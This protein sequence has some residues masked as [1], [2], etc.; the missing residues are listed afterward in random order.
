MAGNDINLAALWVPVMPETK[1]LGPEM[2]KAGESAK[3]EFV[4]GFSGGM[5]PDA[6]GKQWATQFSRSMTATMGQI[7]MPNV[8]QNF[9][10]SLG[11]K[12]KVTE[13]QLDSLKAKAVST[14]GAWQKSLQDLVPHQEKLTVLQQHYNKAMAEGNVKQAEFHKTRMAA[15]MLEHGTAVESATKKQHEFT[16]ATTKL[17]D[18][19][20]AASQGSALMAAAIGGG[21]GA[22]VGLAVSGITNLIGALG[23]LVTSGFRIAIDGAKE[24]ALE[25]V[26]VGE[27]YEGLSHQVVLY[28][29]ATGAALEGLKA[30]TAEVFGNLDVEGKET[31]KTMAILAERLDT[32]PSEALE[33]LVFHVETLKGRFGSLDV[34]KLAATFVTFGVSVEDSDGKLASLVQSAR[35]T[36]GS[37]N[38]ITNALATNGSRLMEAGLSY[39]Q[40]GRFIA[41]VQ[42]QGVNATTMLTGMS[43]AQ[44]EFSER[45]LS[46]RDGMRMAAERLRE[47][48][49]AGEEARANAL[50]QEL[51]GQANWVDAQRAAES[52]L[53]VV[54]STPGAF[55][56]TGD[57]IDQLRDDS[58]GLGEQWEE[59]KKKAEEALRPFGS[60]AIE[61]IGVGLDKAVAYITE[62]H[63]EIAEKVRDYG[64]MFIEA[65]PGIR[66]FA[67]DSVRIFGMIGEGFSIVF[68]GIAV[69]MGL[70]LTNLSYA[71]EAVPPF[72]RALIPGFNEMKD[73]LRDTGKSSMDLGAEIA[74]LKPSAKANEIAEWIENLNIDVP[75]LK[76]NYEELVDEING[77]VFE[78]R[79]SLLPPGGQPAVQIPGGPSLPGPVPSGAAEGPYTGPV[80][81]PNRAPVGPGGAGPAFGATGGVAPFPAFAEAT[82]LPGTATDI[83]GMMT[84]PVPQEQMS[85]EE[86]RKRNRDLALQMFPYYFDMSEWG[87]FEWLEMKEAGWDNLA[88]N[89]SSTAYG[90][91]QF[92]DSTWRNYGQPATGTKDPATQL[93]LMFQYIQG[94]YGTPSAAAAQ[95]YQHEGGAGWYQSGGTAMWPIGFGPKGTDTVPAWL[96]PG[97]EVVNKESSA[98]FR[99]WIKAINSTKSTVPQYLQGG[100]TVN[101]LL[102]GV[103]PQIQQVES[104]ARG[105][106]LTM[107]S[108]WRDTTT[109]HGSGQAGDFG[110]PDSSRDTS[111]MLAFAS[112]MAQNYGPLLAELIYHDPRF[113]G[114][115]I[116][117]GKVTSDSTYANAGDHHDHVHVAIRSE[118][119]PEGLSGV[120]PGMNMGA[121]NAALSGPNA[122]SA[123]SAIL[124][125]SM[126]GPGGSN[127]GILPPGGNPAFPGL[128]GQYGGY[129]AYGAQ[130]YEEAQRNANAVRDARQRLDDMDADIAEKRRRIGDLEIAAAEARKGTWDELT[131]T[132]VVDAAKAKATQDSLDSAN[133][134]LT[135]AIRERGDQTGEI[136][137]AERKQQEDA[138]KPPKT[139]AGAKEYKIPGVSEFTQL[140]GG[141]VKGFA[142]ALGL[143]EIFDK[144]P[145][146][147]GIFKLGAGLASWGLGTANAWAEEI[148]KGHTGVTGFQPMPGFENQGGS[149]GLLGLLSGVPGADIASKYL[150]GPNGQPLLGSSGQ[151]IPVGTGP[152]IS[153]VNTIPSAGQGQ[154]Y[155]PP[156]GPVV[157]GD[158]QPLNVSQHGMNRT[159]VQGM[160]HA[161]NSQHTVN[162]QTG[163]MPLP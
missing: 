59:L 24:L 101:P 61:A 53:D 121:A 63:D 86:R 104:V 76:E 115:Q 144:P 141:L 151:P 11:E 31:G 118:V 48:G 72:T 52:Y 163:N 66:D 97:E 143:G 103:T 162:V 58:Q 138:L 105:F 91:G 15:T 75:E 148:G 130:T 34:N 109:F 131:E 158:Y 147:W 55:T 21:V 32:G 28:S 62:H 98:L 117:E 122:A 23:N 84:P 99:P 40:A 106:G 4:Q 12:T 83:T 69:E 38:D 113:S 127:T 46:F 125:S 88:D 139:A 124:P 161:Q 45:G 33:R 82:R 136:A 123:L 56:A 44:K 41:E 137:D 10:G 20:G 43:T 54:N 1:G 50:A 96:T 26:R 156:P 2:R 150:V 142:D 29:G 39:E 100:D 159:D 13:A 135:R 95:Y 87:A 102:S 128:P 25:V 18:A 149:A 160:Q 107:T 80:G 37:L 7:P 27:T 126:S 93:A 8:L 22:A 114:H 65:L 129:G 57:S 14:H 157:A 6:M 49:E 79:G 108:G 73:S 155:G 70:F 153:A 146:E 16:S 119:A 3:R 92:L 9:M 89:P 145:W 35:E 36:G 111:E 77:S 152:N 5:S 85:V 154:P 132:Y 110:M 17:S 120:G 90:L 116:D 78:P 60:A 134:D 47:L 140:G 81:Q 64:I 67:A 74:K 133:S 51:F 112:Y 68:S 19:T 42:A 30:S 71:M 94:R